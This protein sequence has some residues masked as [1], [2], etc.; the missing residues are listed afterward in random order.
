[1]SGGLTEE[2]L[3]ISKNIISAWNGFIKLKPSH[4]NDKYEFHQAIHILQKTL[5]MR[6]LRRDYPDHWMDKGGE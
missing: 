1:M 2:E 5:G 6:V 3:E 4:P